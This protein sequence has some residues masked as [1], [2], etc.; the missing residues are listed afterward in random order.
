MKKI[1]VLI[2]FMIFVL[3]SCTDELERLP[4]DQF[5]VENTFTANAN[6]ETYAWQLYGMFP[7]YDLDVLDLE[8]DTDL[9]C[10]NNNG[11]NGSDWLQGRIIVDAESEDYSNPYSWIRTANIM[12]DNIDQAPI[13]DVDKNHWRSIGLFFRSFQYFRLLNRYGG[14]P[15]IET[16]I[17]EADTEVLFSARESRDVV[18]ANILRDLTYA[19]Q[20]IIA[21]GTAP[22]SITQDVV[23]ALISRFGL[24]EGTW[25]KYHGLSDADTYLQASANASQALIDGHTLHPN[26]DEVF[27][28]A[29]LASTA[30][31]FLHKQYEVGILTHIITSRMR[32]SAGNWDL[33]K[34]GADTYLFTDGTPVKANANWTDLEKDPYTEFRDRD[35]RM[36]ITTVPPYQIQNP[37][38]ISG[39]TTE[40]EHTG[41]P[42]H[43]EY[44][45]FMAGLSQPEIHQLPDV[46]WRGLTVR[47][48]PHFRK[49][50]RGHG[51]NV[52]QT[53]Y[54]LWKYFDKLASIQNQDFADAPIFR[55]GEIMVNHAEA[56]YE[57]GEFD[58]E[59]ADVS[60]NKLR[61][62]GGVAPLNLTGI[63]EDPDRDPEIPS[64]L[65]EIRR[66]RAVELMGE[67]YRF[68]D[69]RRWRKMADYATSERQVGRW[70][71]ASDED[72]NVPIVGGAAEGYVLPDAWNNAPTPWPDHYYL[73]PIPSNEI[74]INPEIEQNPGW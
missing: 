31:I 63:T 58:Q 30:G 37:P 57:L 55:L 47:R 13:T 25:R 36:L 43:R 5:L 4:Q 74:A 26:Y 14:V 69:L 54:K 24:F 40:W 32:N 68:D 23:R 21:E 8:F 38:G 17:S 34:K 66:E 61:G 50:N 20:N 6:F 59:V 52:T 12:L 45:D 7:G 62:R 71:V 28:S 3:Y 15:W 18:A 70:I 11:N 72:N 53:G 51:Y 64:V 67:G 35:R 60:V 41:D 33:T 19:E 9:M 22:N 46:N 73:F 1:F 48:S 42:T 2:G 56:K 27:N 39:N 44:I 16:A 10:D 49:N 29:D 65:W